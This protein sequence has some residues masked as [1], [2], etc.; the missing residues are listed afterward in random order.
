MDWL[1]SR[2]TACLGQIT[3]GC[4]WPSLSARWLSSAPCTLPRSHQPAERTLFTRMLH[5]LASQ[6]PL[7]AMQG[8]QLLAVALLSAMQA[9]EH[10]IHKRD[11]IDR[12]F[13]AC[14]GVLQYS[15]EVER[16][17][18]LAHEED[19]LIT[20]HLLVHCRVQRFS[21]R[22]LRPSETVTALPP[23]GRALW[24]HDTAP[25]AH[26][27][28][29]RAHPRRRHSVIMAYLAGVGIPAALLPA[30][31]ALGGLHGRSLITL[32]DQ[33]LD[34][35]QRRTA[36]CVNAPVNSGPCGCS[37]RATA[38]LLSALPRAGTGTLKLT[39]DT[40]GLVAA[41][42]GRQGRSRVLQNKA[43]FRE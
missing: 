31:S 11:V 21:H 26:Q 41:N 39:H 4:R 2:H 35:L 28:P 15:G 13:S 29:P 33:R 32:R 43:P 10:S 40:A 30:V 36:V 23:A 17:Y 3:A 7:L 37:A 42:T 24:A 38:C 25:V 19:S 18:L 5:H 9:Q 8:Q 12:Q 34:S 22:H 1:I 27:P 20:G 16:A 6:P 14:C